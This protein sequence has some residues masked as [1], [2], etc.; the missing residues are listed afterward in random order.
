MGSK[1]NTST[2]CRKAA[3]AESSEPRCDGPTFPSCAPMGSR[4]WYLKPGKVVLLAGYGTDST[5]RVG[6]VDSVHGNVLT[7]RF[8]H[9]GQATK[10]VFRSYHRSKIRRIR[11]L[12]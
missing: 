7:L 1:S 11:V 9:E 8:A 5:H 6:I 12:S 4:F 10:P 3:N 2:G